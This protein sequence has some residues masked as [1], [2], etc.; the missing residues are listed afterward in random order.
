M[1]PTF[2]PES[3]DELDL[4]LFFP[5]HQPTHLGNCCKYK[6]Q[7]IMSLKILQKCFPAVKS[8]VICNAPMLGAACPELAVEVTKAGGI[9]MS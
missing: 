7:L 2:L 4:P 5:F 1:V 6:Y 8:P 3:T 9:G